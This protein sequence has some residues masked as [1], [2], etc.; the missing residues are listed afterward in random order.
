MVAWW[1][2]AF[3]IPSPHLSQTKST[4]WTVIS[5]RDRAHQIIAAI[6]MA[7]LPSAVDRKADSRTFMLSSFHQA[8]RKRRGTRNVWIA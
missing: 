6:I 1:L 3:C 2:S 4:H 8:Q 5:N 7:M